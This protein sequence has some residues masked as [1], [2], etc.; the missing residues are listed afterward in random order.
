[1]GLK[2]KTKKTSAATNTAFVARTASGKVYRMAE[3]S[4]HLIEEDGT[5]RTPDGKRETYIPEMEYHHPGRVTPEKP[6]YATVPGSRLAAQPPVARPVNKPATS[7]VQSQPARKSTPPLD[8]KRVQEPWGTVMRYENLDMEAFLANMPSWDPVRDAGDMPPN[9]VIDD[10]CEPFFPEDCRY[11]PSSDWT[12][13]P[14]MPLDN[15]PTPVLAPAPLTPAPA[16]TKA[17]APAGSTR[18]SARAGDVLPGFTPMAMPTELLQPMPQDAHDTFP[19]FRPFT[20]PRDFEIST[21][22]L[23][24]DPLGLQSPH[25]DNQAQQ[26]GQGGY[27]GQE[28]GEDMALRRQLRA[29]AIES[30]QSGFP[31][32]LGWDRPAMAVLLPPDM[33]RNT[34]PTRDRNLSDED[35]WCVIDDTTM[36]EGRNMNGTMGMF[37]MRF[38]GIVIGLNLSGGRPHEVWRIRVNHLQTIEAALAALPWPVRRETTMHN[39]IFIDRNNRMVRASVFGPG[40]NSKHLRRGEIY[41]F[42]GE[43]RQYASVTLI[44]TSRVF[45]CGN[46]LPM[47]QP[48]YPTYPRVANHDAISF[49]ISLYMD[50]PQWGMTEQEVD[51]ELRPVIN[52]VCGQCEMTEADLI[53]VAQADLGLIASSVEQG[54][55]TLDY[56]GS[57]RDMAASDVPSSL[58]EMFRCIHRPR[59]GMQFSIAMKMAGKIN[60]IAVQAKAVRHHKRTPNPKAPLAVDAKDLL[61]LFSHYE[62]ATGFRLTQSQK[63]VSSQIVEALKSPEP[64]SGLLSGD[65]GT[66]KT[67]PIMLTAAVA[68]K[69]GARVA[70]M[71][72]RD[73]LA[74]QLEREFRTKFEGV[75]EVERVE[76][77]KKIRNPQAILISTPGLGTVAARQKWKAD[78]LIVD[79]Q[80]KFSTKD[81]ERMISDNTHV[82]ELSATPI[83]RSLAAS[84]YGGMRIFNLRE[85]PVQK[86]LHSEI[87]DMAADEDRIYILQR[88]RDAVQKGQR[89]AIVYPRVIHQDAAQ[90]E[91]ED[92]QEPVSHGKLTRKEQEQIELQKDEEVKAGV[93]MAFASFEKAFP[94]KCCMLHGK[95]SKDA[96]EQSIQ[97]LRN[98]TRPIVIA[99]TI[100]EIGIDI[101]SVSVMVVREPEYFG[102]SQLHQLRG[103]LVRNGGEGFFIM[104]ASDEAAL[105]KA[106]VK[107]LTCIEQSTDGYE[108]AELDLEARGFGDLD[109]TNQTGNSDMIFR[110]RLK[111]SDCL[112]RGA[113]DIL[114]ECHSSDNSRTLRILREA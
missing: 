53:N 104:A 82:L 16:G 5:S 106:S 49:A 23:N 48:F 96:L 24:H 19:L 113:A 73:L 81:R 65:V 6:R 63:L 11:D 1:M 60:A 3:G 78:Y 25:N 44:S 109:G 72:P 62:E 92:E 76:A 28:Y 50:A 18:S 47:L 52:H 71:T 45:H 67:T 88:V 14:L 9:E 97:D 4:V 22:N 15:S 93:E 70:I 79:E 36:I 80:H 38:S 26:R 77:G 35:E 90:Q 100:I 105:S 111:A 37:R 83:P 101:P 58:L 85:C 29:S 32:K 66:G 107:R 91:Q 54:R 33:V 64:L 112:S 39:L 30:L 95:M 84:I 87:C 17:P 110:G 94:G 55:V 27:T 102:I 89:V 51:V 34:P 103:R 114:R 108:L 61:P 8:G 56:A 10:N 59:S 99:S 20:L 69:A 75:C 31:G 86:T 46:S 40:T 21:Y 43:V 41:S 13:A 2:F 42:R 68:H 7:P 98:G 12:A 74:R 57:K